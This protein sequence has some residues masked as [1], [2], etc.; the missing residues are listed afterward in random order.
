M[1][2]AT[3]SHASLL[4]LPVTIGVYYAAL[5]LQEFAKTPAFNPTLV[6]IAVIALILMLARVEYRSYFEA[7]S[8]LHYLLGA[9]IV[10]LAVPL[11]KNLGSLD[12]RR[13]QILTAL[14]AGSLAS[15]G[16][17]VLCAGLM[18]GSPSLLMSIAPK[19]A[20]AA[21][22]MD[23]ARSVG[24][25]APLAACLTIWTGITGAII[26]PAF[27][28]ACKVKR[29]MARGIALGTVS[30]GIATARAFTESQLT[31]CWASIALTINAVVTALSVPML[32][33]LFKW[34][35]WL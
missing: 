18:G 31:G 3:L 2:E 12:W 16:V 33:Q 17:G 22:S 32:M 13:G 27:L 28:T 34:A 14:L 30:H 7:V 26:G 6:S 11:H 29:S 4:W 10:A 35:G 20:T 9:A 5:R 24:G 8:I 1:I 25:I 23:I 15:F 19:S 21:V